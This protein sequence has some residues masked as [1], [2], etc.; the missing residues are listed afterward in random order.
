MVRR[1]VRPRLGSALGLSQPL[2]GFLATSS[3][4]ALFRAATVPGILPSELSPRRDR[5]PLSRPPCS[6][7]VI[8]RRAEV[9]RPVRSPPVSSTPTPS[10]SCLNPHGGYELHFVGPKPASLS[11]W[12][13]SSRTTSFCQLHLLRSLH[14]PASPFTHRP[15]CPVR[16][17]DTLLVFSPSRAFSD[18]A[19]GSQ[20]AQ[21]LRPGR[22]P[23]S[24]D[25]GS[26]L[27]G[28]LDPSSQVKPPR[29]RS[30]RKTSSTASDPFTRSARTTSRWPPILPWT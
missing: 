28:P 19:S 13:P 7:A 20:P 12:V 10:R 2:S 30:I 22:D 4:A 21:A 18:C 24:E 5:L 1:V 8:H 23:S 15:G 6:L 27:Q 25:S 14:P 26:R 3:F 9:H 11:L 16:A 17:A 29:H